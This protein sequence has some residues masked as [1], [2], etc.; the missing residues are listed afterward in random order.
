M[1]TI[2]SAT[3]TIDHLNPEQQKAVTQDSGVVL[4]IA[5]AGS[6]KTRVIT[7]RITHLLLNK[8]VPAHAILALTFTN[9]AANE[10]KERIQHMI[11]MHCQIPFIGT[12]HGYCLRL[13]K[14][15]AH[16][17]EHPFISI[18][19]E[20]DQQKI[21]QGIIT[22]NNLGKQTTAKQLAY[23]I[24]HIKNHNNN[25][26]YQEWITKN[27]LFAT[28]YQSYEQEKR[29]SKCLDFDDLLIET[30]TL[31]KKNPA[32]KKDFQ[33]RV[34]HILIDEYQDTN[35]I[36]HDLLKQMT[37]DENQNV[38]S[39]SLCV[40]GDED[41]SIYSWRGATVAN[42]V[43]FKTDFP[44]TRVIKI[45]QNYRSVEPIL[46]A[47]NQVIINNQNR[48]PK[49]LWSAKKAQ[50]RIR[51]LSCLSDY[52]EADTIAHTIKAARALKK[53]SSLALLYRTHFQSR[54]L[55]EALL[56]QQVPYKI[57]GGVQFYE[58][59]EIKDLLAHLR[60]L[61][62]PF[63]RMAF[64]RIINCPARGLGQKFEEQFQEVWQQHSHYDFHQV[65]H[66]LIDN[67]HL[68]KSKEDTVK[69][70]VS[71]FTALKPDITA[72][73]ALEHFIKSINY[74]E[75]IKETYEPEDAAS[76]LENVKELMRAIHH[77]EEQKKITIAE[78]LDEIALMQAQ[79]QEAQN[80]TNNPVLLMT[81]H[82]AKGLEFD[83]VIL[84]GM[85][86]GL[87]PS[88][89]SLMDSE[90][91]EEERRLLYVGIT[92]AKEHL[93]FTQS[94]YRYTFGSMSDQKPSRFLREI[95]PTLLN[96]Q[97]CSKWQP[98]EIGMYIKQWLSGTPKIELAN[99]VKTFSTSKPIQTEKKIAVSSSAW[100]TNQ[101][102]RHETFGVGIIKEVETRS[103]T[104]YLTISFKSGTKKIAST[105]ISIV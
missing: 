1:Q 8:Q 31:F 12:F 87:L 68:V 60:L 25:S 93:L 23:H 103:E 88:S 50:D 105:F 97:D 67:H 69:G 85:E 36:Q 81:L 11:G 37:L 49:K 9:K 78:L 63:D 64:F 15:N 46:E 41:Q 72:S 101:P 83:M 102:V 17:L 7:S 34:K 16:L 84:S 13:L 95:E 77:F 100:K 73:K 19:D 96:V 26:L 56:K 44:K 75:H 52:H 6:G 54:S 76:R 70:F 71:L 24:S 22:R 28:V 53:D 4:V 30:V 14:N 90:A 20:D 89:R 99:S 48:H 74:R 80:D 29:A 57:I 104:T 86:D 21:I 59:K 98:H 39:D 94:R 92:R 91:I 2:S 32:F 65:A 61:V 66:Y 27:P 3:F 79:Y 43:H 40:V 47:A 35:V 51:T 62:N 82:A 18:L 55:E 58:R 33:S 38:S 10:M 5:G 45:E 42:I